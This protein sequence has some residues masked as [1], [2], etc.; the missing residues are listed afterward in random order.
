MNWILLLA[1]FWLFN[2]C[3]CYHGNGVRAHTFAWCELSVSL[4]IIDSIPSHYGITYRVSFFPLALRF[5]QPSKVPI[6]ARNI[7]GK[8]RGR[9]KKHRKKCA[10][11]LPKLLSSILSC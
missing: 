7:R 8:I 5:V 10:I 6:R 9:K 2:F 3:V 4:I 1:H 11:R